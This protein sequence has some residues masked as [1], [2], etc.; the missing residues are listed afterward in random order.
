MSRELPTG[1]W[2]SAPAE[3]RRRGKTAKRPGLP[4][5]LD[6]R[7]DE[8]RAMWMAGARA[9][10]IGAAFGVE[11]SR[12]YVWARKLGLKRSRKVAQ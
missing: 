9:A 12:P 7:E 6:G 2:M 1:E 4:S 11:A 8:F 10:D 5:A 3:P